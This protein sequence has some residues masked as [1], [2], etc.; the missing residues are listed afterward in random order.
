MDRATIALVQAS[1]RRIGPHGA[2]L[3]VAFYGR[4]FE[5]EP[6][7]RPLFK[8]DLRKQ[9]LKLIATLQL[10]VAGLDELERIAPALAQL[11]RAHLAYGVQDEH[12]AIVKAALLHALAELPEAQ[13]TPRLR[14]A[15]AEAYDQLTA[16][17]RAAALEASASA[18]QGAQRGSSG[19]RLA[20]QLSGERIELPDGAPLPGGGEGG[21][22][23]GRLQLAP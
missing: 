6:C 3:A 23:E 19:A 11:G 14:A 9:G 17:M 10:A 1:F 16:V 20:R 2:R 4:L 13:L 18:G 7:L 12:Y 21:G 15:W 5:L 22:A 8:G